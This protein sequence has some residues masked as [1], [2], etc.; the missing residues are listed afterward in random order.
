MALHSSIFFFIANYLACP[1]LFQF[2]MVERRS[3]GLGITWLCLACSVISWIHTHL[4]FVTDILSMQLVNCDFVVFCNADIY[5]LSVH[6]GRGIYLCGSSLGFF[7]LLFLTLLKGFFSQHGKFFL[8]WIDGLRTEDV[9]HYTDCK[10]HWGTVI[11]ISGCIHIKL[12]WFDLIWVNM[13][14][15]R[16]C[17]VAQWLALLPHS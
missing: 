7:H 10:V 5:F 4:W 11:V 3:C 17:T 16:G 12:I 9:F 1:T 15:W 6:P 2:T 8:T 13:M 14:K